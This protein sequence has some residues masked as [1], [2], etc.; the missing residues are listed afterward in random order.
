VVAPGLSPVQSAAAARRRSGDRGVRRLADVKDVSEKGKPVVRRGRK[1][2]GLSEIA[3]LPNSTGSSRK[4]AGIGFPNPG[5]HPMRVL[6]PLSTVAAVVVV[7]AMSIGALAEGSASAATS[8]PRAG[9]VRLTVAQDLER[10][11][12][13]RIN[14]FR[15]SHGLRPL[16]RS[17][18]L[19]RAARAHSA[20]MATRGY[21]GHDSPTETCSAR[22]T[23]FYPSAG[24]MT[25]SVGENIAWA[26][27]DLSAKDALQIW[28]ESPEHR[29]ILLTNAWREIGIGAVR[30]EGASRV[31]G[32]GP[33]TIVT[34]NFGDR[35]RFS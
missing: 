8:T 12:L 30:V 28:L 18:H 1:A 32:G 13:G 14:S 10:P 15:K 6:H 11:L 24:F 25:R 2:R 5:G 31:F 35:R 9:A 19:T 34:A 17:P 4:A 29:Q 7:G 22:L 27:P 26:S 21:F 16:S 33:A 20:D 23:R 3:R